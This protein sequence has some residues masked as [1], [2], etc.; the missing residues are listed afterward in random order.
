MIWGGTDAIKT[1]IKWIVNVINALKLSWNHPPPLTVFHET[2][3][4][5]QKCWPP[6]IQG[7]QW[8][9]TWL[10][11]QYIFGDVVIII[12]SERPYGYTDERMERALVNLPKKK[13]SSAKKLE[14]LWKKWLDTK[15]ATAKVSY[16]LDYFIYSFVLA[17]FPKFSNHVPQPTLR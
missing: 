10:A 4:W 7:T 6:L 14:S 15:E 11:H 12:I 13:K 2:D 1:E 5:F 9:D 17:P 16:E 3:P 8:L